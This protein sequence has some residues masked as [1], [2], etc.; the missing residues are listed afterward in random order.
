[1][2]LDYMTF[3]ATWKGVPPV[4]FRVLVIASLALVIWAALPSF[5]VPCVTPFNPSVDS[6]AL[7]VCSPTGTL[8]DY[9]SV[10]K[11]SEDPNAF[12]VL[13]VAAPDVNLYGF[14][15]TFCEFATPCGPNLPQQAYS[16]VFGVGTLDFVHYSIGFA[17]GDKNG[18][19]YGGDP[20]F[21]Y[22]REPNGWYPATTYL[23][24]SLSSLG[25]TAWF[26]SSSVPEP[27]SMLL[28]GS[29]IALLAKKLRK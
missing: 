13:T 5:A 3:N 28:L 7:A 23:D 21:K 22:L 24:P 29:G 1:M 9:V 19:P 26:I 11:A 2:R 27:S 8:Y 20:N 15:T 14:A 25:Y 18:S 10:T 6:D 12:Y 4:K 16:D 17:S